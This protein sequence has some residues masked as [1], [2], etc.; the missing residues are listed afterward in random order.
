MQM[1]VSSGWPVRERGCFGGAYGLPKVLD[2]GAGA[3]SARVGGGGRKRGGVAHR[4]GMARVGNDTSAS[5]GGDG[6]ARLGR[7]WAR[8]G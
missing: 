2:T 6:G 7:E 5:W 3:L 4:V 1:I 8:E